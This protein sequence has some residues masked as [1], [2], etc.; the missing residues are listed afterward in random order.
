VPTLPALLRGAGFATRAVTSHLYVSSVYGLDTGFDHLDFK[1]DRL[2]SDVAEQ[3]TNLLDRFGDRPLFLFLHFYD[4]HWNYTP[5]PSVRALFPAPPGSATGWYREFSTRSRDATSAG[6]L[7]RILALYDGEIRYTND[8]IGR[9]LDHLHSRGLDRST[10]VVVTSDHGEEFLEHGSWE[11]QKTLYE[12][13][14]RIPLLL[15]GPRVTPRIERRQTS[16]LDV[17]PTVLAWAGLPVPGGMQGA[18]LLAPLADREAYGETD[19]VPDGTRKIFLRGG[20]GR[21]KLILSLDRKT[22]QVRSAEWYDLATDPR[23]AAAAA[24]VPRDVRERAL[25]RW[26]QG[27]A[28]GRPLAP[29]QLTPEQI[30]RLKALGYVGP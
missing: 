15:R 4:P 30:E 13:V 5:P 14:L 20:A 26:R 27:R 1:Q 12:E 11:H 9:I 18:S 3:A 23:E 6:D 17:A 19:H 24:E 16:L 22:D 21:S 2:A 10:L 25:A 8:A 28:V 29:V 7:Q